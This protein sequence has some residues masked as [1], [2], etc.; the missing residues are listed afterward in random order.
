M[1]KE[2][3]DLKAERMRAIEARA[4]ALGRRATTPGAAVAVLRGLANEY[5]DLSGVKPAESCR[6]DDCK[7]V[8]LL[9]GV[10]SG[11]GSV[12]SLRE[13]YVMITGD[14]RLTGKAENCS[15]S[16]M[17]EFMTGESFRLT[18]AISASS[19]VNVLGAAVSRQMLR[20]Y[21]DL[22]L[23]GAWRKLVQVTSVD[24]FR[25]IRR[26]KLGGFGNLPTVMQAG[27]Y[28][29]LAS[30]DDESYSVA[31][32]K[33]GGT[34][35]ITLE[36]IANDDVGLVREVAREMARAAAH[37]LFEFVFDFLKDGPVVYDG[38]PLFHVDRGN[39]GSA[40]LSLAGLSGSYLAQSRFQNAVLRKR[41]YIRPK[42]IVVPVDLEEAAFNALQRNLN[43]DK[44]FIQSRGLEV[45]PAPYWTD[46][47][48]WCLAGDPTA[49]PTIE[50]AFFGGREDPE[51]IVSDLPTG[52][53]LFSNDQATYKIRHVYGG[54]VADWRAFYKN[55]P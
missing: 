31:V 12:R 24:E 45:V 19:F 54:A 7:G 53:S 47:N 51:L 17:L 52:G 2:R 29:Q 6:L 21:A 18:E 33:R 3:F 42:F 55:V 25:P 34:E 46:V 10:F 32:T 14:S 49:H 40:A 38:L 27:S 41:H 26:V 9:E 20:Y 4:A 50:L 5:E 39:L 35:T 13:A 15:Q 48:D 28:N 37:T 11:E 8:R 36:S 44:T 30:P 16:N 43:L 22:P 1:L 23:L